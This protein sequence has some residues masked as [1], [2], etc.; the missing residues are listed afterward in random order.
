M[1]LFS[2]EV[3]LQDIFKLCLKEVKYMLPITSIILMNELAGC[4]LK[5]TAVSMQFERLYL[6]AV[7]QFFPE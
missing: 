2:N 5:V 4:F 7:I 3:Y 1:R 6:Y